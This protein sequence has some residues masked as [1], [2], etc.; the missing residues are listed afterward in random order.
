VKSVVYPA[1]PDMIVNLFRQQEWK[2][3]RKE[4]IKQ[5]ASTATFNKLNISHVKDGKSSRPGS[6]KR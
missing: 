1:D 4:V 2:E 3:Y 5:T 6:S